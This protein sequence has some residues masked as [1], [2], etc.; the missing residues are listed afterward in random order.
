MMLIKNLRK[1]LLRLIVVASLIYTYPIW[2]EP[3]QVGFLFA[4][5]YLSEWTHSSKT[6]ASQIE[7][8]TSQS[9]TE[10][11]IQEIP[12]Q[13]RDFS[14]ADIAIGS[15]RETVE[16]A[17][18]V[19]D[20]NY[21][22]EYASSWST[23]HQN[24][25][26]FFMVAYDQNQNV[27]ALYTNQALLSSIHEISFDTT[28]EDVRAILGEPESS[29]RKG[30]INFLI[31]SQGEYDVF[32]IGNCYVTFFYDLHE[33]KTI[34]AVQIIED[35]LELSKDYL[36]AS[37]NNTLIEDFAH[38]LFDLTNSS[39]VKWGLSVLEWSDQASQT[40]IK[41]S[42]D[43][44]V[45]HFFDHT[46]LAGQS[47]FDRMT[48]D[49]IYYQQAGE[50]LAYGQTSSIFAHQGLLNSEGHRKNILFP[51][52]SQLGIGVGFNDEYHP[53]FTELFYK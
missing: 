32:H 49:G 12:P 3:L 7:E 52:F 6:Q 16:G 23:Y 9:T 17:Y 40:A 25:Q 53:Y 48:A 8:T 37:P 31:D 51:D 1:W 10:S 50:N 4:K 2:K 42:Q 20:A 47:P 30:M 19:E 44:A 18:G 38:T 5:N 15:S 45:N 27:Q 33:N 34:T 35:T 43:M 39:R 22:N 24:Y 11:Q 46:N 14:I 28:K 29:I 26:N 41:H 21:Q 36:Y 13:T